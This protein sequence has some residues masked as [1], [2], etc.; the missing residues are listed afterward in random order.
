[1]S[2]G[3]GCTTRAITARSAWNRFPARRV[4]R[5]HQTGARILDFET[6][7]LLEVI[8]PNATLIFAAWIF[9]SVL[10]TRYSA[11]YS[12][13]RGLIETYRSEN[14][15]GARRESLRDQ[16]L[17]YKLR[18]ER[19]RHATNVGIG[20][21][22]LIVSGLIMGGLGVIFGDNAF[23]KSATAVLLLAGL[24]AVIWAAT[25]MWRENLEIEQ[26]IE[27]E[28]SDVPELADAIRRAT[29]PARAA[30]GPG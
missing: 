29:A 30:R 21:A 26:A 10:Q 15:Q 22:V 4:A 24:A 9:L 17:L 16:V 8:G 6:K 19:M 3:E 28:P 7:D 2:M 1:M 12:R 27:Q 5:F 20:S 11:A 13:Y 23:F 18:C 14:P 25:G